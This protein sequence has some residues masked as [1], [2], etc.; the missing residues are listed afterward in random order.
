MQYYIGIDIGGTNLRAAIL[1]EECNLIDKLKISNEVEKGPEYNLDKLILGIKETC[2]DKEIISVGVG[3]P[4]PL[5]IRSGTILVTP[6]LR[7]WEYF[8]LK[9]YLENKFDLPVFVNNDANVAGYSEAMVGAGKGAE[10]VYYMTLSTGIGGGFIYKGEIVSGFNS[11]AAEIGNMIIN[12]DTYKHSNMNYGGLEGQCSGVN[13]ARI[14][15]E[16]IG[17]ELTTK[18]VFE[19]AEQGNMELQKMLSEWVINVSKAIANIIVTVDPEVIVLGGSV[20]INNPSYLNKIKEETQKRVFDGI[21]INIKLAEIGDDTGLIGAGL[22]GK[23][24]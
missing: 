11:I 16:I 18:D 22:L 24:K 19:G 3:C 1:D 7:T 5:D 15:S 4:G 21:K 9:E 8:K 10:S 6:N 23:L 14:S 12:E 2:A 13:I 20:I 17:G